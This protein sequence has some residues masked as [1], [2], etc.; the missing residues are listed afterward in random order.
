[1]A[2]VL[3][4]VQ[5]LQ[6]TD[7]NRVMRV[8]NYCY[9]NMSIRKPPFA[10]RPDIHRTNTPLDAGEITFHCHRCT[11]RDDCFVPVRSGRRKKTF[12]VVIIII[13]IRAA[14]DGSCTGTSAWHMRKQTR[15]GDFI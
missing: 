11:C 9:R 1:M 15:F 7:V 4:F 8:L 14:V 13:L 10:R 6:A 5:N 12:I 3:G 2:H